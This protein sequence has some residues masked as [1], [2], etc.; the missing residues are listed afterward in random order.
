MSGRSYEAIKYW[1]LYM[2]NAL[3]L[4]ELT[5]DNYDSVMVKAMSYKLSSGIYVY[6]AEMPLK[7]SAG[8]DLS[9]QYSAADFFEGKH[10]FSAEM[11]EYDKLFSDYAGILAENNPQILPFAMLYLEADTFSGDDRNAGIFFNLSGEFVKPVLPKILE[12]QGLSDY[13][14]K[15]FNIL[16]KS[17]LF[18]IPWY[19]GFMYSR[20]DFPIRLVCYLT[21]D[22]WYRLPE[23]LNKLG[24]ADIP[25]EDLREL[26]PVIEDN[27]VN[28]L[29]N[30]DVM[31]SGKIGDVFGV[32]ISSVPTII[33]EQRQWLESET[34]QR[35]VSVLKRWEIADD[36]I[37]RIKEGVF[38]VG[39]Q[40]KNAPEFGVI[41]GFSHFKLRWQNGMRLPAKV[42]MQVKKQ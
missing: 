39:F 37:D 1:L 24:Y 26:T 21:K 34:I 2:K 13:E 20:K 10:F 38:H 14:E 18:L 6:F 30:L 23:L 32:E 5:G 41:S 22:G 42:Y 3:R 36:R 28:V 7:G 33:G 29:I 25:E 8:I 27:D 16:E 35:F 40:P 19:F 17:R 12:L 15:L 4:S 11:K 31:E 9:V